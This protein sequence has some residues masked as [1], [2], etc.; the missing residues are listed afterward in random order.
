LIGLG[1][2]LVLTAYVLSVTL[3]G[4][5]LW[6]LRGV[7]TARA[8]GDRRQAWGWVLMMTMLPVAVYQDRLTTTEVLV[9][10]AVAVGPG[11]G[12]FWS[13]L[14]RKGSDSDVDTA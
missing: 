6:F 11:I 9:L 7:K 2:R 13:G 12:L 10:T 1:D 5:E 14:R 8:A 3:A 4:V